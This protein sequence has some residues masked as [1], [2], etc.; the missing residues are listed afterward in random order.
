M[1]LYITDVDYAEP[2]VEGAAIKTNIV[3]QRPRTWKETYRR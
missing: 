2:H 3:Q 1:L